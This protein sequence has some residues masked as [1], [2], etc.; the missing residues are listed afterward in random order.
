MADHRKRALKSAGVAGAGLLSLVAYDLI[1]K[2]H[3]LLRNFPVIGHL[4]FMLEVIRPEVQQYFIER[5]WDG[6]PFDRDTRAVIYLRAKG[7]DAD[8]AYGTERDV[9]RPGYEWLVHSARPVPPATEEHRIT[10]GG[11]DCRRPYAMS[12][13]NVSAMSFGALSANAIRA[14]N[15][16]AAMGGFLHDTG[17]GGISPYHREFG[18]DLMWE[19]GSGYFGA[20]TRDGDFDPVLFAERAA[21]D[22]VKCVSLKLSQ[23]AKPGLGG[24]LP[25]PKVSREIAEIRGVEEGVDCVSPS[26]HRTFTT[27]VELIEFVARIRE[28]S[29]GKPTG[30]K[31]CVGSRTDVLAICKAMRVVGTAPD[32]I[33]VDGS[34]GG[35]GAAPLE[36]EDNVGMPLTQGLMTVHNALVGTGLRDHIRLG[37]SGKI[38]RASDI[39]KRL[40]QGADFTNSARAMMMAIG[41]IQAQKCHTGRC[42]VGVA[43]QDPW[44]QRALDVPTK[45]ERVHNDHDATVKEVAR[46]IGAMGVHSPTELRPWQLRQNISLLEERSYEELY[47]WLRPGELLEGASREWAAAWEAA[48]PHSFEPPHNIGVAR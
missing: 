35:T 5:N 32:F 3:S 39:V 42:P 6:R 7:L 45:A 17:E 15:Q 16:G 23:G 21:D 25:A 44:R 14:L 18:G 26:A 29:G 13:L 4:R 27:P 20:R 19:L 40:I 31:L 2:K 28:L 22:Q 48:D 10:V 30:I 12:L 34:E 46:L 11:P 1:Q 43:T 33:I 37:A 38:A 41:C 47:E 8:Q 36:F 24:I 9:Y